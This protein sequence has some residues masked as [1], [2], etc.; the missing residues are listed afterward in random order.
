MRTGPVVL[1][2]LALACESFAYWG[3]S[4]ASGRRAFDEMAGMIPVAAGVTG[5][6]LAVAA[7]IVW[8]RGRQAE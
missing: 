5:I 2:A 6:L 8:W 4:T 1:A 7:S 3:L